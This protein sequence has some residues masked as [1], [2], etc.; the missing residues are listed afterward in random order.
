MVISDSVIQ[1]CSNAVLQKWKKQTKSMTSMK[2]IVGCYLFQ[3]ILINGTNQWTI[4]KTLHCLPNH[5]TSTL[6]KQRCFENIPKSLISKAVQIHIP[7]LIRILQKI[8]WKSSKLWKSWKQQR[9]IGKEAQWMWNAESESKK[10]YS[11]FC[12]LD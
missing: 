3:Q 11:W 5:W 6:H 2:P 8:N 4:Q 12:W 9:A 10:F 1:F 7:I